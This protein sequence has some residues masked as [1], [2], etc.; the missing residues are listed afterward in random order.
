VRIPEPIGRSPLLFLTGAGASAPLG[1]WTATEFVSKFWQ[2]VQVQTLLKRDHE[3]RRSASL[4]V[5]NVSMDIEQLL[6]VFELSALNGELFRKDANF[7]REVLGN[8]TDKLQRFI[9]MNQELR[10]ALYSEVIDHYSRLDSE[11]AARLYEP[12]FLDFNEWFKEVPGVG[13]TISFFTLNYDTAVEAAASVLDIDV[14]DG[15]GPFRGATERRWSRTIFENYSEAPDKPTIVLFKLHGSVRWG[16][17][18]LNT[19]EEVISELAVSVGRDPGAYTHAVLYPTMGPKPVRKEP[20]RTG[21]RFFRSCLS[22]ALVLFVI[23]CSL[24]DGEIQV[25]LSDA[26]DDNSRLH[27]VVIDPGMDYQE[28]AKR[29]QSDPNR[30]AVVRRKFE[31]PI[32]RPHSYL[33]GCMRGFAWRAAGLPNADSYPFGR[34]YDDWPGAIAGRV[35]GG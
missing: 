30:I 24:R 7:T 22:N 32:D 5:A 18:T 27:I 4:L 21:Y 1:R 20:F 12:W 29:T 10:D 2:S 8:Q 14:I 16:W 9:G 26:M 17:R 6:E 13:R 11:Q 33:M 3:I 25:S 19:G 23:G 35:R 28:V 34:T 31:Q 15:I